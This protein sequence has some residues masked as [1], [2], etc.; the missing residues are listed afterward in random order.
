ML[1]CPPGRLTRLKSTG[2]TV[3]GGAGRFAGFVEGG[4]LAVGGDRLRNLIAYALA[5]WVRHVEVVLL[6][7]LLISFARVVGGIGGG[8]KFTWF[9]GCELW[10]WL[11]DG[12]VRMGGGEV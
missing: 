2:S 5:A 11:L 4:L 12:R 9:V 1:E 3:V 6:G 10:L 8:M 7:G